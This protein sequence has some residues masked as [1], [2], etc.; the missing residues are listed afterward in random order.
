[1]S[2]TDEQIV[3]SFQSTK[4]KGDFEELVARHLG[5]IRDFAYRMIL[6]AST[7]DDIAQDV[8]M[9]AFRNLDNFRGDSKF[10]TWLYRIAVNTVRE[11]ERKSFSKKEATIVGIELS[12]KAYEQPDRQAMDAELVESIEHAMACL[13]EKLRFAFVLTVLEGLNPKQA[14]AIERCSVATMYWRVHQARKELKNHLQ[15]HLCHEI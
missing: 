1:M 3:E 8:F 6:C 4:S 14:A 7:A 15:A 13:S 9:K 2:I 11:Y 10:T 12:A 5:N